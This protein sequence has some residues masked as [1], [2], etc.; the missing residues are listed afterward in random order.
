MRHR[1]SVPTSAVLD[2]LGSD[3]TSDSGDANG[4]KPGRPGPCPRGLPHAGGTG[5]SAA[6]KIFTSLL[7]LLLRRGDLGVACRSAQKAGAARS[8]A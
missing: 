7:G 3:A 2:V 4:G 5:Q 6:E 8:A 1:T